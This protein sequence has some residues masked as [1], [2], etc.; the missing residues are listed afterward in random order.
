MKAITKNID[1][2]FDRLNLHGKARQWAWFAA[3]WSGSLACVLTLGYT[4]KFLMGMI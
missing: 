1:A 2:A 3:L 4:I